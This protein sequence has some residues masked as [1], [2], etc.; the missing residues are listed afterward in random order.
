[1]RSFASGSNSE[2]GVE[3]IQK[4]RDLKDHQMLYEL[5]AKQYEAAHPDAAKEPSLI[6]VLDPP[7]RPNLDRGPKGAMIVIGATMF[8]FFSFVSVWSFSNSLVSASCWCRSGRHA[9]ASRVCYCGPDAK[10]A[11]LNAGTPMEA[12]L[13]DC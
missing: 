1:M 9:G 3:N 5:M 6:Q 7:S 8:D 2:A 13:A 4:M 10:D 11:A 12:G